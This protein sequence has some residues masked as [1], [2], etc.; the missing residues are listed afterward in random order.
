MVNAA[1]GAFLAGVIHLGPMPNDVASNAR[2]AY[3]NLPIGEVKSPLLQALCGYWA[4]VRGDKAM[5]SRADID[6]VA[7]PRQ[8]LPRVMMFD[9][10]P[11]FSLRYR[12]I[13]TSITA[14]TGRDLTGLAVE[15]RYYGDNGPKFLHILDMCARTGAALMTRA[16]I[17]FGAEDIPVE[18][19]FLPLGVDGR[20]NILLAGIHRQDGGDQQTR[21]FTYKPESRYEITASRLDTDNDPLFAR[22]H[23]DVTP[24]KRA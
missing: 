19:V 16:V 10:A 5:P 11:D 20:V 17:S 7:I 2:H 15:G 1:P 8:V 24:D 4:R 18:S 22:A 12:L 21:Y 9:V 3:T 13:G 23:A 14:H 6:P